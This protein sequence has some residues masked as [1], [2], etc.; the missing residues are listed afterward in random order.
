MN[1]AKFYGLLVHVET[2]DG[3]SFNGKVNDYIEPDDNDNGQ[4]SIIVDTSPDGKHPVE[5]FES[6][7]ERIEALT[8]E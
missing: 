4:E 1:L 2:T 7:I 8:K 6:D 3:F 5:L